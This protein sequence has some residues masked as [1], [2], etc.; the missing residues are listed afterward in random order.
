[1]ENSATLH[2]LCGKMAAGKSTFANKLSIKDQIVVICEDD[3]LAALYPGDV[4]DVASYVKMSNRV[5]LAI[6]S[7]VVDLLAHGTSLILDFSANTAAQ[8][9]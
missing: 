2:L 1:M 3:L 4:T 9:A 6:E 7:I 5:K 8:R